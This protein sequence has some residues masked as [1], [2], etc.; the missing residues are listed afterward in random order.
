MSPPLE[1]RVSQRAAS[2]LAN[3]YVPRSAGDGGSRLFG[4]DNALRYAVI[5][6][7]CQGEA[8]PSAPLG[9]RS[10]VTSL[11]LTLSDDLY[12]ALEERAAAENRSKAS[13]VRTAICLAFPPLSISL[14]PPG[15]DCAGTPAP[16]TRRS[17]AAALAIAPFGDLAE[18]FA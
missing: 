15:D 12:L 5:L 13:I 6:Y 1:V 2:R 7:L 18:I 9:T 17:L 10:A 8:L 3:A 16:T 14:L 11:L 4:V